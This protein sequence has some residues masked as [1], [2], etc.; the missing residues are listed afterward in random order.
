MKGFFV[1][2]AQEEN[3]PGMGYLVIVSLIDRYLTLPKINLRQQ[4]TSK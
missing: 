3:F 1:A 4:P 2:N